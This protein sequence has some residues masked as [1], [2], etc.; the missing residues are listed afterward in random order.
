MGGVAQTAFFA[1][2]AHFVGHRAAIF[3]RQAA[4]QFAPLRRGQ[5]AQTR[6]A[7]RR[8]QCERLAHRVSKRAPVV[9]VHGMRS[10]D[11]AVRVRGADLQC[12]RG[13]EHKGDVVAQSYDDR[14]C[15]N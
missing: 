15:R 7:R 1:A 2:A 10:R 9:W 8:I 6:H 11:G 5:I 12:A 13:C 4:E 14:G 3:G